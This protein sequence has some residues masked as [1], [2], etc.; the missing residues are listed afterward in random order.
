[1][2]IISA[3]RSLH[4]D[5]ELGSSFLT[6]AA[7]P[8]AATTTSSMTALCCWTSLGLI[9]LM[10]SSSESVIESTMCVNASISD[11]RDR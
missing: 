1:M 3:I 7:A 6:V 5:V 11:K 2:F 9:T 8:T 10:P 4:L